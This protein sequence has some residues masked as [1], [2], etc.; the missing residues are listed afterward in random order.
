[1]APNFHS[2]IVVLYDYIYRNQYV[3]NSLSLTAAVC[4]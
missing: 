3:K 2:G 4:L 1:M